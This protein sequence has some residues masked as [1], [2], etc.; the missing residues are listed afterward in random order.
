MSVRV[1]MAPITF[2]EAAQEKDMDL[3]GN[4]KAFY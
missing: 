1:K 4:D 3:N 2:Q